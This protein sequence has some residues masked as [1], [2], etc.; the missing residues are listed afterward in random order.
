MD[1]SRNFLSGS[2]DF[3][4]N[5]PLLQILR[6]NNNEFKGS[7]HSDIFKYIVPLKIFEI[8]SNYINGTIPSTFGTQI[9]LEIFRI[10]NNN[11]SG[12][13]P[14]NIANYFSLKILMA[15]HNKLKGALPSSFDALKSNLEVLILSHNNFK[16]EFPSILTE[17]HKLQIL[18]LDNN[19]F[20]GN[21]SN[22]KTLRKLEVLWL[23]NN[24]FTGNTTNIANKNINKKLQ[25][26][27]LSGNYFKCELY[28]DLALIHTDSPSDTTQCDVKIYIDP[29]TKANISIHSIP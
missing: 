9:N 22:L 29:I 1:L 19:E 25:D 7:I 3:I 5:L 14:Q 4:A 28:G 26:M 18:A 17:F 11:I 20:Y 8:E 23:H 13:L 2:I 6:L 24:K 15:S 27:R 12:F 10:S 21:V 16:Q